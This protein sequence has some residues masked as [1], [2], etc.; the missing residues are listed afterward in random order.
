MIRHDRAARHDRG[1]V[2]EHDVA[3]MAGYAFSTWRGKKADERAKFKARVPSLTTDEDRL[4]AYDP[5]QALAYFTP[6]AEL[7]ALV[8]RDQDLTDEQKHPEDLLSDHEAAK[9]RGIDVKTLQ[10]GVRSG[11]YT[12]HIEIAGI[13]W[14][15]RHTLT[16]GKAGRPEGS[17]D[18]A[19]RA[20]REHPVHEAAEA[21]VKEIAQQLQDGAELTA[22]AVAERYGV[23]EDSARRYLARARQQI[24][25][26]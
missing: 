19:P 4:D 12:G 1:A 18:S 7:P 6:D 26:Q 15:P 22:A 23:H 5:E 11:Q 9:T 16:P 3:R 25:S 8:V 14:W 24:T 17:V 10:R 13:R 21:R 20:L 2:S